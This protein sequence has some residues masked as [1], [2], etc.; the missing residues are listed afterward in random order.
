MTTWH[1]V[2]IGEPIS[3]TPCSG[4]LKKIT[5]YLPRAPNRLVRS[6]FHGFF[7]SSETDGDAEAFLDLP[8]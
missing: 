5:H 2:R 7:T 3:V 1:R 6:Y 8:R 4:V